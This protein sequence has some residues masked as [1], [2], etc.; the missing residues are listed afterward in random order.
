MSTGSVIGSI[1]AGCAQ[2]AVGGPWGCAA[3]AIGAAIMG[4]FSKPPKDP[5]RDQRYFC[6]PG[7]PAFQPG[8]TLSPTYCAPVGC[9]EYSH[10]TSGRPWDAAMIQGDFPY[11]ECNSV[12]IRT[13]EEGLQYGCHPRTMAPLLLPLLGLAGILILVKL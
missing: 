2:G 12:W 8:A 13:R 7:S 5:Y 1:G 9:N 11:C 4:F 6:G 10:P 3:G